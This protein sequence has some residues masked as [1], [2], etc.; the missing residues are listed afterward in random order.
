MKTTIE[1]ADS[2]LAEAKEVAGR[3]HTTIRALVEKGLRL[4]LDER[5]ERKP[6][7]LR[8]ASVGGR[9]L[10]P[11]FQGAGWEKIRDAI[12]EGRGA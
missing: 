9:G 4:V 11:E 6:F 3:D 8:D 10:K 12:Y 7:T 2:L 1:I 5:R